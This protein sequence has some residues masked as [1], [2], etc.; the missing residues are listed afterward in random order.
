MTINDA[1]EAVDKFLERYTGSGGLR[2]VERRVLPSSEDAD[3][4]KVWIDLGPAGTG[5]DL[6]AW[7]N[8]CESAIRTSVPSAKEWKLRVKVEAG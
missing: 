6:D 8:A 1:V 7:S 4:I 2:P 5:A 3:V